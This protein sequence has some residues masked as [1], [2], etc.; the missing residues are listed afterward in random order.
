MDQETLKKH[1][2]NLSKKDFDGIASLILNRI[3]QLSAIDVD[4]KGDGGSDYR[5]FSDT[6]GDRTLAIQ[7]TVQ[8]SNWKKKAFDDAKK[9][10][11]ERGAK[12]YFFITSQPHQASSFYELEE[13][14]LTELSLP[15]RFIGAKEIAGLILENNLL[16]DFGRI[17]S[18]NLNIGI[19]DRPDTRERLL[20]TYFS[21]SNDRVKMQNEMYEGALLSI[22]TQSKSSITRSELIEKG[23]KFLSLQEAKRDKLIGRIDALL[24]KNKLLSENGK[25]TVS[26]TI[27]DELQLANGIYSKEMGQ[28]S[29]A[30]ADLVANY[31]GSWKEEDS[32][33]AAILL[34]KCFVEQQIESANH[35]SLSFQM[36][37][38]GACTFDAKMELKTMI[39]EAGV[40]GQKIDLVFSEM[41]QIAQGN[42]IIEKITDTIVYI[43]LESSD[44]SKCAAILGANS[45]QEVKVL[46]DASV[47]IPFLC[48][49][50]FSPTKGRFSLGSNETVNLLKSQNAKLSIPYHYLNECASH[51]VKAHDYCKELSAFDDDMAYSKN[52]YVAHYYQL[53]ELGKK[54]PSSLED[55]LSIF[56]RNTP[57]YFEERYL[58]IRKVMTDLQPLFSEYGVSFEDT[59][60]VPDQYKVS[61]DSEYMHTLREQGRDDKDDGLVKHDTEILSHISRNYAEKNEKIICLTWDRTMLAVGTKV[62][63][64][65]WIVSPVEA[66]DII[67]T[68]LNISNKRL[69][70]LAHSV[71]RTIE[72]PRVI[73]ARILDRVVQLAS[74]KLEDWEFREKLKNFKNEALARIDTSKNEYHFFEFDQKTDSFLKDQGV[75]IPKRKNPL[76]EPTA[77]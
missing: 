42:P 75:S 7:K 59:P 10:K 9:A 55:Y 16:Y 44:T 51:L 23:M 8:D 19:S 37:G 26:P 1:I 32:K 41:I 46:L 3:F 65:G 13:K 25:I 5:I 72:F 17:I 54:V 2:S 11:E 68:R 70:S 22:V 60:R 76:K 77:D 61:I 38:F 30:Q 73:G 67:Q 29:G 28:L 14:I 49:S 18:L 40:K 45:W 31:G 39:S 35:C 56:S 15:S 69:L 58:K 52:G 57:V 71:A 27:I 63:V 36:T 6:A 21:L 74:D 62:D 12:R 24:S 53:K 50:L 64:G 34:A 48:S 4:G 66:S 20:Y 47:A 33:K 43:A